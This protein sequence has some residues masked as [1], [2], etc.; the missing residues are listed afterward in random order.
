MGVEQEKVEITEMPTQ[1]VLERFVGQMV[2]GQEVTVRFNVEEG[3]FDVI[4]DNPQ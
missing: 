2:L 1:E 3:R 4:G